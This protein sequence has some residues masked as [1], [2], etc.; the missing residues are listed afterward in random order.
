MS[1]KTNKPLGIGLEALIPK[2]QTAENK[3]EST[4]LSTK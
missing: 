1:K 2:Y 4:T 3:I